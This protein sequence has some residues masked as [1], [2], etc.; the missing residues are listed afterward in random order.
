LCSSSSRTIN[1]NAAKSFLNNLNIP[2]GRAEASLG[3]ENYFGRMRAD[4]FSNNKFPRNDGIPIEF[5]RK[6]WPSIR[7]SFIKCVNECFQKGEMYCSQKQAMITLI[8]KKGKDRT[9]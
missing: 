3:G 2:N 6:L 5:Y 4:P 1:N 7:E 9:L 8:E